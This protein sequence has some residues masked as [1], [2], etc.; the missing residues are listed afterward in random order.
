MEE[1]EKENNLSYKWMNIGEIFMTNIETCYGEYTF[2][3][4]N[5]IHKETKEVNQK[6]LV[7]G[8]WTIIDKKELIKKLEYEQ[9]RMDNILERLKEEKLI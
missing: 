5:I 8:E 1:K 7:F 6:I 3:C 9:E 4:M 2:A